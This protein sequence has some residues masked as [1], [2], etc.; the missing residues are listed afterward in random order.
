MNKFLLRE[1]NSFQYQ[2]PVGE[3]GKPKISKYGN[4]LVKGIIQRADALN[5][6]GRI[7]PKQ[8]LDR[9]IKNYMKLVE[10]RRATGCLDHLD[11]PVVD[12]QHVSHVITDI[13]WEGND[14]WGEVEILENMIQGRQLKVL[15]ENDIK[16]GISSRALGS[17]QKLGESNI[18]QD[19][20]FLVCW[21]FVSEPSTHGAFMMM[22]EGKEYSEKELRTMFSKSDR[23]DRLINSL[24]EFKQGKK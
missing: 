6:N 7:Y 12:L 1:Y 16:V 18:V 13:W 3:D 11:S 8:V 14:V 5:Q 20:L 15:L 22:Q 2:K 17:V 4:L 9:E 24:L 23:L 19:D 21:D 10:E